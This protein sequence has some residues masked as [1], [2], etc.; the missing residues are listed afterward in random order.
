MRE[1]CKNY[2][3]FAGKKDADIYVWERVE[4]SGRNIERRGNT[5]GGGVADKVTVLS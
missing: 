5:M 1:S 4:Q 3:N 2:E